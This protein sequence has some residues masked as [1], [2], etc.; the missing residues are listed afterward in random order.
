MA[1]QW[2]VNGFSN[3]FIGLSNALK[4][5]AKNSNGLQFF[6]NGLLNVFQRFLPTLPKGS[7]TAFFNGSF[8]QYVLSNEAVIGTNG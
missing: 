7:R 5:C 1:N 3:G 2:V 8:P 4:G 6:S